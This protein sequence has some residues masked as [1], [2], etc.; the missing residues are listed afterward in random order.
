MSLL[1]TTTLSSGGFG[2][3][4]SFFDQDYTVSHACCSSDSADAQCSDS[5]DTKSHT[6]VDC[7]SDICHCTC[8]LHLLIT[9]TLE[10]S[11]QYIGDVFDDRFIYSWPKS[12]EYT[13][14]VFIPPIY[15]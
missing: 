5:T 13:A 6:A 7:C 8:C 9:D 2:N 1:A 3:V 11:I 15:S 12:F 14:V 4:R 10:S